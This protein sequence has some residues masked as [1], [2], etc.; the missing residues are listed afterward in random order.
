MSRSMSRSRLEIRHLATE[1]HTGP[2]GIGDLV[3][4][5]DV[6]VGSEEG[7]EGVVLA[8]LLGKE[9]ADVA[10]IEVCEP[11]KLETADRPVPEFHLGHG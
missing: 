3:L 5:H 8:E 4:L 11:V 2:E 1:R 6:R 10:S 9:L 7:N